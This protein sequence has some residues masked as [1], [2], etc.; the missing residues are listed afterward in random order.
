MDVWVVV[1]GLVGVVMSSAPRAVGVDKL[2]S[3]AA[4]SQHVNLSG[5]GA[6]NLE[7]TSAYTFFCF[8][9]F[10]VSA[11]QATGSAA[12]RVPPPPKTKGK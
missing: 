5:V 11:T 9:T 7:F 1:I 3:G 8:L 12:K 4:L 10:W 6:V 2:G